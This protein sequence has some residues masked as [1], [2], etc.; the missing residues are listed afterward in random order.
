MQLFCD[1]CG[2]DLVAQMLRPD[3]KFCSDCGKALSEYVKRQSVNLLKTPPKSG[4][5]NRG[6]AAN[7]TPKSFGYSGKKR[8]LIDE[9]EP[10]NDDA[11]G[12]MRTR[13]RPK[14]PHRNELDLDTTDETSTEENPESEET[15]ENE[16]QVLHALAFSRKYTELGQG[17]WEGEKNP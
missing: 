2:T 12:Q 16:E 11:V 5:R 14:K 6:Y 1:Q 7:D 3:S 8:K 17:T 9:D 13:G 15:R 10:N 4:R